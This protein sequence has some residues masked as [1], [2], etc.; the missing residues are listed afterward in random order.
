MRMRGEYRNN[1]VY[2]LDDVVSYGN[3][4]WI[5]NRVITIDSPPPFV[6]WD[7]YP[8]PNGDR[9]INPTPNQTT[10]E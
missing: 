8:N 10:T 6:G 7:R 2:L 3:K 4:Y 5:A 9:S 1:F